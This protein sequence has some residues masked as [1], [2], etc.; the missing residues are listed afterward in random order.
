MV[1]E[2]V[3]K[4]V[5]P[6]AGSAARAVTRL[7]VLVL[8]SWTISLDP[9][10]IAALQGAL[11]IGFVCALVIAALR[12]G[13]GVAWAQTA[14]ALA[15]PAASIA[16]LWRTDMTEA[17]LLTIIA[18]VEVSTQMLVQMWRQTMAKEG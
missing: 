14:R 10:W 8:A 7:V 17:H 6:E 16:V 13:Y 12:K 2:T 9:G 11:E 5:D 4:T 15:R 18:A 1:K 3:R